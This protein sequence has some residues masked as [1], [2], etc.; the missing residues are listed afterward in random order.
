[1]EKGEKKPTLQRK[2]HHQNYCCWSEQKQN[3]MPEKTIS[4]VDIIQIIFDA[5]EQRQKVIFRHYNMSFRKV[6]VGAS[7]WEQT[8]YHGIWGWNSTK[9]PQLRFPKL[10]TKAPL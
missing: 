9:G 1:M 10:F 4:L 2:S 5:V 7:S 8:Q 3:S 6:M